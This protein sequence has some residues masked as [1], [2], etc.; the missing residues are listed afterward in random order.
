MPGAVLH[1]RAH[2]GKENKQDSCPYGTDSV[3]VTD[4][5]QVH[6]SDKCHEKVKQ[7]MIIKSN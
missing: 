6:I 2:S 1:S 4:I 3:G 5:K 7:G